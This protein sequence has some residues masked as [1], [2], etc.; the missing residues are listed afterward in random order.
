VRGCYYGLYLYGDT[1]TIAVSLDSNSVSGGYYGVYL[2]Y[3]YTATV[4]GRMNRIAHNTYGI[5]NSYHTTGSRSFRLG[6]IDSN[7]TNG[8]YNGSSIIN[9]VADSNY[10]GNPGGPGVGANSGPVTVSPVQTA[11][12]SSVPGL[13][14]P[15]FAGAPRPSLVA[16][17]AGGGGAPYSSVKPAQPT[18][19]LLDPGALQR[20]AATFADIEARDRAMR[21]DAIRAAQMRMAR[22][23]PVARR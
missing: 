4:S 12:P 10:W 13:V 5:Y 14:P 20:R 19:P 16:S 3:P 22:K 11:D 9:F 1:T 18:P 15:I 8:V 6:V 2:Y 21:E 17:A 7:S 23:S